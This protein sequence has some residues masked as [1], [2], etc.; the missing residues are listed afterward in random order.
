[1][2]IH[3]PVP[4]IPVQEL[5]NG[6]YQGRFPMAHEDG[7]IYW[8]DPDPRAVF[9]LSTIVPDPRTARVI[10]S[11]RFRTTVDHAFEAVIRSC[12]D[13]EETWLDERMIRSYLALHRAG[14]AFSVECWEGDRLAGGIYGVKLGRAFFGESMFGTNNAGKVAFHALVSQLRQQQFILFDTQYINPFTQQLGAMEIPRIIFREQLKR[15]IGTPVNNRS[16][17]RTS[18]LLVTLLA[19]SMSM[20]QQQLTIE[21]QLNK[22]EAGGMLNL[23]LCP[24]AGSY[25]SEKG[26][27]LAQV[28]AE[29]GVVR[30]VLK[31]VVPGS[32]A[33]KAFHDVDRNGKLDTNFMGIPKEPYGFSNDAMGTFGPP[34]FE[35]A[36]FKVGAGS[37]TVRFKMKG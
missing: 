23:V 15:A 31:D 12:A 6:Y 29:G 10:R 8:H 36:S 13:R 3:R 17:M 30:L 26:C 37:T 20:A 24:T 5:V 9:D 1:M 21:V 33:I 25:E 22:P 32:Y 11:G 34:S 18:L 2:S 27:R 4:T 14:L 7:H 35:Q 19:G 28:K 16:L